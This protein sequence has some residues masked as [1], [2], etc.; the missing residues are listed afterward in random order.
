MIEQIRLKPA[1]KPRMKVLKGVRRFTIPALRW[2]AKKW[3][4]IIDWEAKDATIYEPAIWSKMD[5]DELRE[6]IHETVAL[7]STVLLV[8]VNHVRDILGVRRLRSKHG[9]RDVIVFHVLP[10]LRHFR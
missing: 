9:L 10:G 7:A 8:P 3:W 6:V 2:G 4:D 5:N 1:K